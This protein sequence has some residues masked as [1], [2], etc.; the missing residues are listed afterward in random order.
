M[1][2]VV[3]KFD[4]LQQNAATRAKREKNIQILTAHLKD[5]HDLLSVI[6]RNNDFETMQERAAVQQRI[7]NLNAL[8][9]D[10]KRAIEV[11]Y[12]AD[13][14]DVSVVVGKLGI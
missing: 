3:T 7:K 1:E 10:E 14:A 6:P 13:D 5:A 2:A 11:L 9:E 12:G 8:I 4:I